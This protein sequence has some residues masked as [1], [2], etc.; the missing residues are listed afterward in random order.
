MNWELVQ[1]YLDALAGLR[2][3]RR[4]NV[5]IARC[6]DREALEQNQPP[7]F[8]FVSGSRG[9]YNPKGVHCLYFS[10]NKEIAQLE[11]MH[12]NRSPVGPTPPYTTFFAD[13]YLAILDL[14]KPG[15]LATLGF[16]KRAL[17]RHWRTITRA[18]KAE[19]LG[20]AISE[21]K[22]FSAIRFPSHAA[23]ACRRIGF[24]YA[25]FRDP[26]LETRSLLR[27]ETGVG[28]RSQRWP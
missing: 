23:R 26:M 27:V 2:A 13:A 21:Q 17:H 5:E 12:L 11:Y 6:V 1:V 8:L 10:E 19:L 25:I 15:V 14:S 9:R 20:L 28:I 18:T 3:P 7:E 24:N 16:T 22:R 4:K